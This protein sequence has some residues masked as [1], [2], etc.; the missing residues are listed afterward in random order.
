MEKNVFT[1]LNNTN[2]EQR[3]EI[4]DMKRRVSLRRY[5][6]RRNSTSGT[7]SST[8]TGDSYSDGDG[9]EPKNRGLKFYDEHEV[10]ESIERVMQ[11]ILLPTIQNIRTEIQDIDITRSASMGVWQCCI[12]TPGFMALYKVLDRYLPKQTPFAIACRLAATV[13]YS[14][15]NNALFFSYGTCVHHAVEWYDEK[16]ILR[17]Q[18]QKEYSC[19]DAEI[20]DFVPPEFDVG[21]MLSNT[22]LKVEAE[23]WPTVVNSFKMWVPSHFVNFTLVPSHLRPLTISVL[24]IFWNCYLSLVQHRDICLPTEDDS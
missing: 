22:R 7:I 19:D 16:S 14:I 24:S 4:T 1:T 17:D 2:D 8:R 13:A 20:A 6:S 12:V 5:M 15:P 10:Q 21:R 9:E 18:Y 23:L 11:T 3:R